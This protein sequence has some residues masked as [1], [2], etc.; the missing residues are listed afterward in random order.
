MIWQ[1]RYALIPR[2]WRRQM[3]EQGARL[4]GVRYEYKSEEMFFVSVRMTA[5]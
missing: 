1:G 2:L 3:Q 5:K 4:K